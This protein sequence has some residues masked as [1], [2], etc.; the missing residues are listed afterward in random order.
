M[1]IQ[2]V[3]KMISVIVSA[4][5]RKQY[6]DVALDSLQKQTLEKRFFEVILITNFD[7]D[8]TKFQ[9]L[10]IKHIKMEGLD[11][12]YFA[13]G[14]KESKGNIICFL[15]D[16]DLYSPGKLSTVYSI[17]KNDVVYYRHSK[18]NF[19]DSI[20]VTKGID[21]MS[22]R[23]LSLY[24]DTSLT[25][26]K[27]FRKLK[28]DLNNTT[29]SIRKDLLSK[30]VNQL[31][32]LPCCIDEFLFIVFLKSGSKGLVDFNIHSFYRKYNVNVA[33]TENLDHRI[34]RF[35]RV[36]SF[37]EMISEQEDLESLQRYYSYHLS[38][39][40]IQIYLLT[41]RD[42]YT[43]TQNDLQ[44]LF[45]FC[46]FN[47]DGITTKLLFAEVIIARF[48]PKFRNYSNGIFKMARKLIEKLSS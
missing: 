27:K 48:L 10:N 26:L 19:Y 30:Y 7:Y 3:G 40:R 6:L 16:D 5:N 9:D 35:D 21:R 47:F 23:T 20:P 44:T 42:T 22:S 34:E 32:S 29:I 46:L 25:T 8:L 37:F 43:P 28:F 11:G 45:R 13:Q 39:A 24:G 33:N 18:L 17:F 14:M 12:E 1:A 38:L 31:K 2:R 36:I 15:D 4:Y 41:L